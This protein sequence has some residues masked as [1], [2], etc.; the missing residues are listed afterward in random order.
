MSYF[1]PKY[2][3]MKKEWRN[4]RRSQR[5][6]IQ[7]QKASGGWIK[8]NINKQNLWVA[9]KGSTRPPVHVYANLETES[10]KSAWGAARDID[11][12]IGCAFEVMHNGKFRG[13]HTS[14]R[15]WNVQQQDILTLVSIT[16]PVWIEFFK[17]H[18]CFHYHSTPS[19]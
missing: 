5:L 8:K 6:A 13:R 7:R 3:P 17:A 18:P 1:Q 2:V 15:R 10:M 16:D 14:L 9:V 4:H 19:F 12:T 11:G